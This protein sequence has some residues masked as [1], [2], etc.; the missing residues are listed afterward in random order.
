MNDCVTNVTKDGIGLF[1]ELFFPVGEQLITESMLAADLGGQ[2]FPREKLQDHTGFEF[3]VEKYDV[4]LH[5]W[6]PLS[7]LYLVCK[8][9][10]HFW[11]VHYIPLHHSTADVVN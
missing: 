7:G 11:G 3:Q 4:F 8:I 1:K 6:N 5:R 9:T 10:V 2:F